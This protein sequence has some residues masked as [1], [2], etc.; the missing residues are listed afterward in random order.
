MT[1]G[2]H[3]ASNQILF[4]NNVDIPIE[5][6]ADANQ[7]RSNE[8]KTLSLFPGRNISKALGGN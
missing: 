6:N 7:N 2:F 8:V 5:K 3:K 4:N 1:M